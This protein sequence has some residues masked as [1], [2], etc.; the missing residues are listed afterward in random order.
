[1]TIEDT[2]SIYGPAQCPRCGERRRVYVRAEQ[3]LVCLA[4][5]KEVEDGE[6]RFDGLRHGGGTT[7]GVS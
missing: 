1:M 7:G 6:D 3:D 4:C 5:K 2:I